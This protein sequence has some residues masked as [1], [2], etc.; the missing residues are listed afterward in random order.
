MQ[1]VKIINLNVNNDKKG[2]KLKNKVAKRVGIFAGCLLMGISGYTYLRNIAT[3]NAPEFSKTQVVVGKD[4]ISMQQFYDNLSYDN[5]SWQY[6]DKNGNSLNVDSL[7]DVSK[8]DSVAHAYIKNVKLSEKVDTVYV[9]YD[10]NYDYI[11]RIGERDSLFHMPSMGVHNYDMLT[12]REFITDN[13]QL[14]KRMDVYND[15]YNCTYR[16]EYQHYLN[17]K[18]GMRNWNSYPIK[19]AENCLDEIS[20]NIAQCLEQ[21][22]NYVKHNR[23]I[24]YITHRFKFYKDAVWDG[25]VYPKMGRI[26]ED[27]LK[28]IANGV[29]DSWMHDKYD[30][31][32]ENNFSRTKYYLE[33]AP[34]MAT[35]ENKKIHEETM[36]KIFTINGY[37]FWKYISAREQEIYDKIPKRHKNMYAYLRQKKYKQMTYLDKLEEYKY[38]NGEKAF[39]EKLTE[40]YFKAKIIALMGK[41]K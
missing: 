19:F 13:P 41:D 15:S 32:E 36:K 29:F 39:Q 4:T 2:K 26:S 18:S 25:A 6:I 40:N 35:Q 22:R 14:Q 23:D 33:N 7:C 10:E 24:N 17:M 11:Y 3:D 31:Y 20:A 28:F 34:Y 30:L 21:R 27:E 9:S 12:V 5:G 16:H 1:D 8:R 38:E 37:D